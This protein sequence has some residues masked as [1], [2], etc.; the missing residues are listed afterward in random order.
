[1]ADPPEPRQRHT[2]TL[3]NRRREQLIKSTITSIAKRGFAD[4]TLANVAEGVGLS[5][6]IVNFHFTNKET[7]LNDTLQ[8]LADEYRHVW[9]HALDRAGPTVAERLYALV[10]ADFDP[11]VYNRKKIA[12][13]FAFYGES[14]SRPTYLALCEQ[15]DEQHYIALRD[16]CRQLLDESGRM[17]V[18]ADLIATAIS[19]IIDGLWLDRLLTPNKMSTKRAKE[20]ALG[21]LD[22]VFSG[23]FTLHT[24]ATDTRH[25]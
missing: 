17:T 24:D 14:K 16:L 22:T 21:Y 5:R 19:A 23:H 1:M 7:L 3:K 6:G 4:T 10:M 11:V 18:D 8:Y 20:T 13:W 2:D 15:R 9:R 12:V 25:V